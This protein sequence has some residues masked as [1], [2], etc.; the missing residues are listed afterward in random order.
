MAA[1]KK[2]I[3]DKKKLER[4]QK[5]KQSNWKWNKDHTKKI[6]LKSYSSNTKRGKFTSKNTNKSNSR[7]DRPKFTN[8]IDKRF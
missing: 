3:R 4:F 2:A 1:R 8:K 5:P 6:P 7:S